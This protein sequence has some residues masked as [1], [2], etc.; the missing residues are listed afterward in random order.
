A[1]SYNNMGEIA[2]RNDVGHQEYKPKKVVGSCEIFLLAWQGEAL[3]PM[4]VGNVLPTL[5]GNVIGGTALF[6]LIVWAQVKD[7]MKE[8]V[9]RLRGE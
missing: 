1:R 7:E 3:G 2:H 9:R 4:L 8:T 5:L 6:A